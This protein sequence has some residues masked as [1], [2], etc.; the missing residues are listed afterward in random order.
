MKVTA[1]V[2]GLVLGSPALSAAADK[3]TTLSRLDDFMILSDVATPEVRIMLM[4]P[5][6]ETGTNK[7]MCGIAVRTHPFTVKADQLDKILQIGGMS[8]EAK[9]ENGQLVA[10][11]QSANLVA[12]VFDIKTRS[13]GNLDK[14]IGLLDPAEKVEAIVAVISCR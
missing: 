13:G 4:Y 12:A 8:G 2:L 7:E 9:V 1:L 5:G 6:S 3:S 14:E 11:V 10:K